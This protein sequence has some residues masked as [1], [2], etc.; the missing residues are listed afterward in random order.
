LTQNC[1]YGLGLAGLLFGTPAG[2]A[3]L[4]LLLAVIAGLIIYWVFGKRQ[5]KKK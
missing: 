4:G 1:N 2:I 3:G 5:K